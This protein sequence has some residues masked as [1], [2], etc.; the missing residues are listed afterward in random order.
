LGSPIVA[1][2]VLQNLELHILDKLSFIPSFYVR[3]MDDVVLAARYTLFDELLNKLNSFHSRFKF[4][5]KTGGMKLNFLELTISDKDGWMIFNW[6]RKATF[7]GRL[8]NYYSH[9][10]SYTQKKV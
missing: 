7:S 1:D 10:T 2:L 9:L 5:M 3:Y 6:Y 8:L 4:T